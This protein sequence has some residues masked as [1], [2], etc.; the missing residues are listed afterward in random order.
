MT[1]TS[2]Y[3]SHW[4][5][6]TNSNIFCWCFES[7]S[8]DRRSK[9]NVAHE[10]PFYVVTIIPLFCRKKN[11]ICTSVKFIY[12]EKAKKICEIFTLILSY[13]VPVK[14]KVKISQNVVAFSEY[15]NFTKAFLWCFYYWTDFVWA[16]WKIIYIFMY[17]ATFKICTRFAKY[18]NVL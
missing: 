18:M 12:S 14:S 7:T 2:V 6:K 3:D 9:H 10:T 8:P 13:V 11:T 1:T 17:D 16:K 5:W 15:M 4:C